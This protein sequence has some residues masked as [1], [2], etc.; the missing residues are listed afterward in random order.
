MCMIK[1]C[2]LKIIIMRIDLKH[3]LHKSKYV[4]TVRI[5]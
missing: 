1:L 5:P 2:M 4:I 3:S